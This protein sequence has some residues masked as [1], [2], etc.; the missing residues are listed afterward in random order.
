MLGLP[1]ESTLGSVSG[2]LL[3]GPARYSRQ[4]SNIKAERKPALLDSYRANRITVCIA[5]QCLAAPRGECLC[6][7]MHHIFPSIF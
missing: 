6:L 7:I 3:F 5:N 4:M 1:K 2:Y